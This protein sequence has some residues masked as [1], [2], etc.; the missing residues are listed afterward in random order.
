[1]GRPSEAARYFVSATVYDPIAWEHLG[2]I[3][4]ELGEPEKARE[5]YEKFLVAWQDA[6]PAMRPR[7]ERVRQRLAGIAPLRQE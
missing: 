5:S 1:M 2:P 3:Y 4:E 7:V 6:E